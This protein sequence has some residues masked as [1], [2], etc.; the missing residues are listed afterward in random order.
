MVNHTGQFD[1][2]LAAVAGDDPALFMELREAF[3]ESLRQQ[4]D[5]LGRARCDG[6]WEVAA[7]RLKGLAASFHFPE[8]GALAERALDGPPGEPTVVRQLQQ[9]CAG[10]DADLLQS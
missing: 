10:F 2:N 9:L 8:L 6:N 3:V 4:V 1:A 5:L 7:Q